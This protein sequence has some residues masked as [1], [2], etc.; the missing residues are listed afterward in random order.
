MLEGSTGCY[1]WPAGIFLSEFLLANPAKFSGRSCLEIGAGAGLSS[2]CLVLLRASKVIATDGNHSTLAN[3]K[4][5][6]AINA[7]QLA[8]QHQTN[9]QQTIVECE[10]L[11]WESVSEEAVA[12]F[13]ADIIVGADLIYDPSCIGDLVH[14]LTLFLSRGVKHKSCGAERRAVSNHEDMRNERQDAMEI[15]TDVWPSAYLATVIRNIDTMNMFISSACLAGLF[16][17][18]V[19]K[20]MRPPVF[21]PHVTDI[22][23]SAIRLHRLSMRP[24]FA[25]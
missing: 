11:R 9:Q 8:D 20:T 3:L 17:E 19:T 6:F 25:V 14:L 7:V 2:I 24:Y 22:D 5:N 10:E 18:D 13:G 4:H 12:N 1:A 15:H 23:R 16:V 21:L